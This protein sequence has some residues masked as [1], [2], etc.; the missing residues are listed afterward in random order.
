[1]ATQNNRLT[2]KEEK[3][4]DIHPYRIGMLHAEKTLDRL[5]TPSYSFGLSELDDKWKKLSQRA[6][7]AEERLARY[8]KEYS[9]RSS[10]DSS[11][12]SSDR[13]A[14]QANP[15]DEKVSLR[16][17]TNDARA[18]V[19]QY[20]AEQERRE[21]TYQVRRAAEEDVKKLR[22]EKLLHEE[23]KKRAEQKH[24]EHVNEMRLQAK[25]V[26]DIFQTIDDEDKEPD[27][28]INNSIEEEVREEP[29]KHIKEELVSS[30]PSPSS[31]H[32]PSFYDPQRLAQLLLDAEVDN[33]DESLHQSSLSRDDDNAPIACE[34]SDHGTH[35]SE[36]APRAKEG[37]TPLSSPCAYQTIDD[38][39][40]VQADTE[41][42]PHTVVPDEVY[43]Y[44][45]H[46]EQ[47]RLIEQVRDKVFERRQQDALRF[48]QW[49]KEQ[50][51]KRRHD[52]QVLRTQ[53]EQE[54]ARRAQ[55]LTEKYR[56]QHQSTSHEIREDR[57]HEAEESPLHEACD[58]TPDSSLPSDSRS[59][60][61]SSPRVSS[62]RRLS[63][64][65][66]RPAP[67]PPPVVDKGSGQDG[68]TKKHRIR[69]FFRQQSQKKIDDDDKPDTFLRLFVRWVLRL[70]ILLIIALGLVLALDKPVITRS[71]GNLPGKVNIYYDV[72]VPHV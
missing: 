30:L 53:I 2:G 11:S 70:A 58:T 38:S 63:P 29:V 32:A 47:Q 28:E 43:A 35:A 9:Y 14:Y 15:Q 8:D 60:V 6:A 64:V 16:P 18:W 71:L 55:Q 10:S 67:P 46:Q 27:K 22:Y 62:S 72:Y 52:E 50:T 31:S 48:Q 4:R 12:F 37:I 1:M 59:S 3:K 61:L 39:A 26:A 54:A 21:R 57:E 36:D 45:Y 69:R 33:D 24:V 49:K 56:V 51:D 41:N 19:E 65:S 34:A 23:E 44:Y 17:V 42:D 40:Q 7:Y 13:D 68:D 66:V 25:R 20:R 5:S